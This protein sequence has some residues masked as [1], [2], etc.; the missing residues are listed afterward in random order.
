PGELLAL[1]RERVTASVV[2]QRRV[3]LSGRRGL[4]VIARRPPAGGVIAWAY[5]FDPG[6]DP[7]DPQ[8]RAV[9]EEGLRAAAEELGDAAGP[10]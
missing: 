3:R 1:V 6:V 9:A 5:R 4:S 10:I 2:L 7:D 8:V